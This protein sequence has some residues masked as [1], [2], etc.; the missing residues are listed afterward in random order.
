MTKK[1]LAAL[2]SILAMF[3]V[4]ASPVQAQTATFAQADG[5]EEDDDSGLLGLIGLAGLLGLAGLARRDR[6]DSYRR[7]TGYRSD[8]DAGNR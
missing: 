3:G 5:E 4:A 7:D 2:F 1:L 6:R 8:I